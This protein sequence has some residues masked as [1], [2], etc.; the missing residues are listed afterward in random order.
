MD[1][2]DDTAEVPEPVQV[3]TG[4]ADCAE[5]TWRPDG[6]ALAFVSARHERADRDL[7]RTCTS[8]GVD[9]AG[10]RR[11]TGSVRRLS[12]CPPTPRTGRCT[13]PP[14]PISA[15]TA[16]TSSRAGGAVPGGRRRGSCTRC[17]IRSRTTAATRPRRRSSSTARCWS[18]SSAAERWS[19]CACRWTGPSP[20][21]WSAARSPSGASGR[22]GGV[23]VATVAHDRSAGE[24]IALT[25]GTPAA[26]HRL[27]SPA[28][29][30]RPGAPHAPS[31]PRPRRTATPCTAG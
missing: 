13:S 8:C 22:G 2:T 14:C 6:A 12:R 31:G 4:D 3:T 7:V 23:V 30:D 11:V 1:F 16:S 24:L 26:A 25:P 15:P 9:G 17:S 28:R 10:L 27:R 21:P 5:V 19:S 18:G 20:R 29:R